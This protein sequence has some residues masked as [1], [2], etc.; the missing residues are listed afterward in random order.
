MTELLDHL[1]RDGP[2]LSQ[3]VLAHQY[4]DS[5]W[6]ERFGDKGRRHAN[7]DSDFHL[8]YLTRALVAGDAGVL[9]RYALWLRE[10]LAARGMC[11][12]HLDE[13]F[14]LLSQEIDSQGWPARQE[15]VRMLVQARAAL[16]YGA[17]EAGDAQRSGERVAREVVQLYRARFPQDWKRDDARGALGLEDDAA[18]WVSYVA[19]ALAFGKPDTL[20]RHAAWFGEHLRRHGVTQQQLECFVRAASAE[21]AKCCDGPRL[22]TYLARAEEAALAPRE[23]TQAQSA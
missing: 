22:R 14:R 15:A 12:R 8:R 18:N 13:N 3:R 10:V 2:A 7:E 1:S 19:D 11:T 16:R 4:R 20:V 23:A 5:F 21:L 9:E 6:S 17:G